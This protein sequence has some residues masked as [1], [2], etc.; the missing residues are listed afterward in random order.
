LSTADRTIRLRENTNH[1][2]QRLP[3]AG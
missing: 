3:L 1:F 2:G